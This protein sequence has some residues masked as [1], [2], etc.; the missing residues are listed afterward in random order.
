M[1]PVGVFLPEVLGVP[2]APPINAPPSDDDERP[3][4]GDGGGVDVALC[5]INRNDREI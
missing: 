5:S 3:L 4:V 2:N 1:F